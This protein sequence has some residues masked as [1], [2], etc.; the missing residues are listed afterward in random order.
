MK[1][2]QNLWKRLKPEIKE[3]IKKEYEPLLKTLVKH[4]LK[5]NT[6]PYH[7]AYGVYDTIADTC[8]YELKWSQKKSRSIYQFFKNN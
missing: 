3:T 7:V 5:N 1:K 4:D 2:P 8:E 6:N